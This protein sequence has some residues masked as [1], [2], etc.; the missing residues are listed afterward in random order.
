MFMKLICAGIEEQIVG[1]HMIGTAAD[2]VLQGIGVAI[3]MGATKADFDA[4]VA[5]HPTAA[6]EHYG[7][8]GDQRASSRR[9]GCTTFGCVG[10]RTHLSA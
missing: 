6:E 1:L 3:K 10:R 8:K 7:N 9:Q 5:T 4:C 2:E